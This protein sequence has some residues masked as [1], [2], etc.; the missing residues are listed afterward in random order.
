M[1]IC[2]IRGGRILADG[3]E[4]AAGQEK[5]PV[6]HYLN[7]FNGCAVGGGARGYLLGNAVYIPFVNIEGCLLYTSRACT[8]TQSFGLS[9]TGAAGTLS[10]D[11]FL[12]GEG[13]WRLNT[14]SGTAANTGLWGTAAYG[15]TLKEEEAVFRAAGILIDAAGE[16]FGE[17]DLYYRRG[18]AVA[19]PE[20][21]GYTFDYAVSDGAVDVYKRQVPGAAGRGNGLFKRGLQG[22]HG[23][24]FG[25]DGGRGRGASV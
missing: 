11:A 22:P 17:T 25:K 13:A 8:V 23:R 7:A 9:A 14:A 3:I 15:P 12:N 16:Q 19:F 4:V 21:P 18:E 2:D 5:D 20:Q 24:P 10:W 1:Q 6:A